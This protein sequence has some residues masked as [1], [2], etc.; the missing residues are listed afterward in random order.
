MGKSKILVDS[1]VW[2]A[3]YDTND[4]QHER[5]VGLF[6]KIKKDQV[7]IIVHFL[8]L[9]ETLSVLK[10]KNFDLDTLK[11]IRRQ[12]FETAN[13]ELINKGGID[14]SPKGWARF[15]E[16]NKLGVVDAVL[17]DYCLKNKVGLESFDEEMQVVYKKFF[18]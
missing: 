2:I 6:K 11:K 9:I 16:K 17:I 10:Y 5:A 7:Q 12:I 3:L 18:K 1:C 14:L 8:V 4:R 13:I 15:E